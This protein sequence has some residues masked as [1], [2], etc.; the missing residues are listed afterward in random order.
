MK[1]AVFSICVIAVTLPGLCPSCLSG[2]WFQERQEKKDQDKPKKKKV[3]KNQAVRLLPVQV[4]R[5]PYSEAKFRAAKKFLVA[6]DLT[7]HVEFLER[8]CKIDKNLKVTAIGNRI[9][10]FL[11][12]HLNRN[13]L[14]A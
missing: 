14:I 7:A 9:F 1:S 2:A 11:I 12:R 8:I 6:R 5:S 3:V 4:K 10:M 13:S